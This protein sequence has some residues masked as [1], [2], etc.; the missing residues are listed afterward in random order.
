M[1]RLSA[2]LMTTTS[3]A[4]DL[5]VVAPV[6]DAPDMLAYSG[7]FGIYGGLSTADTSEDQYGWGGDGWLV[8][9]DAKVNYWLGQSFS[10]QFT[11]H[12]EAGGVDASEDGCNSSCD[13]DEEYSRVNFAVGGHAT[14]RNPNRGALGVFGGITG[15]SIFDDGDQTRYF[16]GAEG[17]VYF[18]DFT[19]YGQGGFHDWIQGDSNHDEMAEGWFIRGVG[20]WFVTPYDKVE[21]EIGYNMSD[22]NIGNNNG[23]IE[24]INWGALYEHQFMNSPVSVY[25]EYDG[26]RH[27]DQSHSSN[28]VETEHIF[29]LGAKIYFNQPDLQTADRYGP[30]L[31]LPDLVRAQNWADLNH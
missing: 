1:A 5:P 23:D 25:A 17:Q 8:G 19:L 21:G 20:R 7:V 29:M 11:I 10:T 3:Y 28:N 26:Y 6:S 16:I 15:G 14:W 24:T 27:D 2:I 18:G 12:G 30:T 22:N 13:D 9:G 31:D 4:A